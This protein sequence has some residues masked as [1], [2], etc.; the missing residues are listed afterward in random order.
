MNEY[1]LYINQKKPDIGLYVPKGASLPDFAQPAEWIYDGTA[2]A[3][4]LPAAV[5]QGVAANGHAF[6]PM[7]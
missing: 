5:V 7:D 4:V 6:R 3:D 2:T 1:D